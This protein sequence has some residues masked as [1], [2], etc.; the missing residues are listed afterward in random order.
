[1]IRIS[2]ASKKESLV[3]EWRQIIDTHYGKGKEW[4]EKYFRFKATENGKLVGK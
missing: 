2:K 4:V 3:K 1:M